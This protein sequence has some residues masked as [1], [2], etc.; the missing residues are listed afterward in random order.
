[1]NMHACVSTGRGR[2]CLLYTSQVI[3]SSCT[4]VCAVYLSGI[5]FYNETSRRVPRYQCCCASP[6]EGGRGGAL[7]RSLEPSNIV[8][9]DLV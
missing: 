1:M 3:F 8:T 4:S 2:R 7:M 5:C 9:T 6:V